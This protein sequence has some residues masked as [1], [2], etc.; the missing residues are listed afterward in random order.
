MSLSTHVLDAALGRPAAGV[1]V[2]LERPGS[3]DGTGR[4]GEVL[5]EGVTDADGRIAGW[6]CGAGEHRLV[7]DTGGYFAAR[8]VKAFY[9][10]VSIDFT[11]TDPAEHHHVPL[12][13]SPFAYSTY[14]GS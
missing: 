10:R 12:L 11:V 6:T 3:P 4:G 5:A 14:R 9:P 13:L 1:A 7:F 8:A 2:R